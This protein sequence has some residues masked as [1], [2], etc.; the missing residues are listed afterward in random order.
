MEIFTDGFLENGKK[1]TWWDVYFKKNF[2]KT[3]QQSDVISENLKNLGSK[4]NRDSMFYSL[5]F[6]LIIVFLPPGYGLI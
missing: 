4:L 3:N 6:T 5:L 1:Q 2:T